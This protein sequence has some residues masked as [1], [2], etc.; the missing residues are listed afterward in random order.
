MNAHRLWVWGLSFSLLINA[1][2][3]LLAS[4]S[5]DKDRA[6]T[7][8]KNSKKEFQDT[9]ADAK[10]GS[11]VEPVAL[12][13]TPL[14]AGGV[15]MGIPASNDESET[16]P[17]ALE[18]KASDSLNQLSNI[19]AKTT[20]ESMFHIFPPVN[21]YRSLIPRKKKKKKEEKRRYST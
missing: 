21:I 4:Q 6:H 10:G 9:K 18:Q 19:E 7:A 11:Y 15:F 3:P 5:D 2:T 8:Q 14:L 17:D 20:S 16:E 12:I 1:A 13:L